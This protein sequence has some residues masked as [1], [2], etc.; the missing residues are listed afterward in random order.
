M[1]EPGFFLWVSLTNLNRAQLRK[2]LKEADKLDAMNQQ[3]DQHSTSDSNSMDVMR[4]RWSLTILLTAYPIWK[5]FYLFMDPTA[6]DPIWQ[7]FVASAIWLLCL[8]STFIEHRFKKFEGAIFVAAICSAALHVLFLVYMNDLKIAYIL[9][10]YCLMFGSSAALQNIRALF[11]YFVMCA[12]VTGSFWI[13]RHDSNSVF[14]LLGAVCS[15]ACAFMVSKVLLTLVNALRKSREAIQAQSIDLAKANSGLENVMNSLGQGFFS[16]GADGICNSIYSRACLTLLETNP[17]GKPLWDV[18]R[19]NADQV[20]TIQGWINLCFDPDNRAGDAILKAGMKFAPHSKGLTVAIEYYPVRDANGVLKEMVVVATDKTNEVKARKDA[21][22]EHRRMKMIT[23]IVEQR[24]SFQP[25]IKDVS[26]RLQYFPSLTVET[27]GDLKLE[28]EFRRFL[29]TIKGGFDMFAVDSLSESIHH[30]ESAW[31]A[32]R[33]GPMAIGE[34]LVLIKEQCALLTIQLNEFTTRYRSVLGRAISETE[35]SVDVPLDQ[36]LALIQKAKTPSSQG[37]LWKDLQ[38]ATLRPI[39]EYFQQ[40]SGLAK[41]LAK[42]QKKLLND[43][44][45]DNAT[46]E[47]YPEP[48][49]ELFASFV[50]VFRNAVDH[51]LESPNERESNQ[52]AREGHIYVAFEQNESRLRI[53]IKDDGRGIDPKVIREKLSG[54][55]GLESYL[56][57]NDED[58]IQSVFESNFTTKDVVT[59]ISGRGIGLDA[60]KAAA[61][62]IG[63]TVRVK[64]SIGHGTQMTV[65]VP[66]I[67]PN[68]KL[69]IV[70]AVA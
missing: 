65:E 37:E 49:H 62:R 5:P 36:M 4:Y 63:G 10:A 51:G 52:K 46:L 69:E 23:T 21:E 61:N 6:Y 54:R 34:A 20:D 13:Q 1:G 28:E 70:K 59:A 67:L 44:V 27:I 33:D 66:V 8:G 50:H 25:F 9:G 16:F 55:A 30:Q 17:A 11:I 29:H 35:R 39:G 64:S 32:K 14:L 22:L 2:T 24:S 53:T 68:D 19:V 57:T 31:K 47:I 18:L 38:R 26:E 7:R 42:K 58:V 43:V 12:L 41:T 3:R 60:L 56:N 15:T 45:F 48:Y 40:Y